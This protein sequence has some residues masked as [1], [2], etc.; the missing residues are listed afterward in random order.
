MK[1]VIKIIL[2]IIL[3]PIVLFVYVCVDGFIY[4]YSHS[5]LIN[6]VNITVKYD[7][8]MCG[9]EKPLLVTVYNNSRKIINFIVF[10]INIYRKGY[11]IN[12]DRYP[13]SHYVISNKMIGSHM[14][15]NVCETYHT[16]P[17]YQKYNPNDL[18]FEIGKYRN[19][20]FQQ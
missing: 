19:I 1:K 5:K 15:Y 12:I 9:K 16:T 7:I 14:H 8:L 20:I 4:D 18:T 3:I 2:S 11:N 10:D 6:N 17:E 13:N